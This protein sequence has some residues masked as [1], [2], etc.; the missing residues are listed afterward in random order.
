MKIFTV[1]I[2]LIIFALLFVEEALRAQTLTNSE[3]DSLY[4]NNIMV[5]DLTN[6]VNS[7]S[8]FS[9]INYTLSLDKVELSIHN[10][11]SSNVS[12]LERN[13]FRDIND[14]DLVVNYKLTKSFYAGGGV[15]AVNLSDDKNVELNENDNNFFFANFVFFPRNE[16]KLSTRLGYKNENQIGETSRAKRKHTCR[17]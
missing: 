17:G 16:V 6:N 10:K 3:E 9:R 2:I 4:Q 8:L 12:K 14:L 11:Y 15:T 5:T 7:A 1:K 13:F